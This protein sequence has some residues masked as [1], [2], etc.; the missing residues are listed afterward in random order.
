MKNKIIL[1]CCL[2]IIFAGCTTD[3]DTKDPSINDPSTNVILLT[4]T[5]DSSFTLGSPITIFFTLENTRGTDIVLSNIHNANLQIVSIKKDNI[6][7]VKKTTLILYD[8]PLESIMKESLTTLG[9]NVSFEWVS[10][11]D[12]NIPGQVFVVTS[13]LDNG[14]HE[15]TLYNF[16]ETGSYEIKLYYQ[17]P[18]IPNTTPQPFLEASNEVTIIF[19][20]N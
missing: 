20:I 14:K 9:G 12:D 11:E 17:I 4:A 5:Y 19:T 3:Q 2:L 16:A 13:Y 15:A 6:D 1:L 8:H 7:V 18:N 10:E